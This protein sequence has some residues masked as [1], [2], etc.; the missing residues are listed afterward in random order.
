MNEP[1]TVRKFIV[2]RLDRR[3]ERT[4][5]YL[6]SFV[7]AGRNGLKRLAFGEQ[8]DAHIFEAQAEAEDVTRRLRRRISATEYD[9]RV[10]VVAAESAARF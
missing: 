10:E 4:P 1:N 7:L 9:Y 3:G 2:A 5:N 6:R 8:V